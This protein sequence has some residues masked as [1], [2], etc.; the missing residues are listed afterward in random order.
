LVERVIGEGESMRNAQRIAL[1]GLAVIGLSLGAG[2]A[3][4]T[5]P[6]GVTAEI[7]AQTTVGGKDYVVRE[8]TIAPGGGTG[9][10]FHQGTLYALVKQG[11]L[12]HS[13][14]DCTTTDVYPAGSTFIEPSGADHVH[15]GRNL[16][17][18]PIVLQVLYVDPAGAPL[19]DDAANPGCGFE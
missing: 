4:A 15:I 6:S 16:G 17:T 10:H 1:A 7:L 5:P 9:W 12:T 8:I 3:Q 19:S 18:T 14:A 11:T 2:T 13:D